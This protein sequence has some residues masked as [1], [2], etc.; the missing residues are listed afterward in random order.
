[1]NIGWILLTILMIGILVAVHELGHFTVAKRLHFPVF[2]YSIGMGPA[3]LK[4]KFRGTQYSLRAFPI[5]GYVAFDNPTDPVAEEISFRR[6][7][8]GH[9][10][11]VVV[12]GPLMN[13]VIAIL[14]AALV[15]CIWGTAATVPRIAEVTADSAAAEAGLKPGDEFVSVDGNPINGDYETF[16]ALLAGNRGE[17][18]QLEVLRDGQTVS[19]NVTPRLNEEQGRYMLGITMDYEYQRMNVFKAIGAAAVW[20]FNMVQQMLIFLGGLFRGRGTGD[21]TG[22]VGAVSMVSEAGAT[23]GM[24]SFLTMVSYL[25]INLGIMNLLPLPALDGGKLLLMLVEKIRGGKQIP[26][27][28]EGILNFVFLGLFIVLFVIL[29]FRDVTRIIGG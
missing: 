29:T 28:K 7:P 13:I 17:T 6:Q 27:E 25:S 5:G 4:K 10:F 20:T 26:P 12:A 21:V 24:S 1:M 14:I 23:Y 22:I 3:L 9:R 19:L 15:L 8:L 2:E 16:S 11:W 18:I